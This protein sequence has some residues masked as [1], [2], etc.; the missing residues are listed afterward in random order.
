MRKDNT[1]PTWSGKVD[2]I[3]QFQHGVDTIPTWSGYN[4]LLQSV[5]GTTL[6]TRILY[7]PLIPA[8]ASDFR[9][10][11]TAMENAKFVVP[12]EFSNGSGAKTV[13]TLDLDLYERAMQIV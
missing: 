1:I 2:T 10:V 5:E 3:P 6:L 9:G 8:P 12:T 13:I 4:S 11:Y 7:F